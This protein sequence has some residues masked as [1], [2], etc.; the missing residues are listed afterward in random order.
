MGGPG[1]AVLYISGGQKSNLGRGLLPKKTP[2]KHG[3][4]VNLKLYVRALDNRRCGARV[5][6]GGGM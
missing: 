1:G 4:G 5:G 6:T 3:D 2:R